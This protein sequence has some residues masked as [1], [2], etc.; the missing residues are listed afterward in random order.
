MSI[1]FLLTC[2][3]FFLMFPVSAQELTQNIRGQIKDKATHL[4]LEG[5]NVV[6]VPSE[7]IM[8]DRSDKEGRFEIRKIPIGRYS[9]QFTYLGYNPIT[10]NDVVLNST[11]EIILNIEMEEKVAVSKD[12]VVKG[13]REKDKPVNELAM[14]SA[15]MFSVEETGRY[16]GSLN[17]PARMAQNFAGVQANG[18]TRNDIIIRGNSPLGV[19]WRLEGIDIPNPN[20]F[21]G[22]GTS[23]GAI[24][25]LN[26]N[27][28]SNSDFLTGAFPAQYGNALAG[29][30]DLRLRNGN[31]QHREYTIM[32][33]M[34]GLEAGIEG[35]IS[36][37]NHSSYIANYRYSTLGLFD[38][39]GI[40]FGAAAIPKY[41]DGVFKLNLPTTHAGEF[42][43][44]GVGGYNSSAFYS[45]DYDTTGRKLNPLPKG[46]N[47]NFI[48]YMGV[49][50]LEHK[51]HFSK[52]TYGK[53]I[54]A[55]SI[56]GNKTNAD[57]LYNQ[58]Q[59]K[60]LWLRRNYGERTLNGQYLLSTK[61][62]AQH[63]TQLGIYYNQTF[64]QIK[65]S[66]YLSSI[67]RYR[68]ILDEDGSIQI[69]RAFVQHQFK[70]NEHVTLVAGLH[71]QLFTLNQSKA[72]EPR[73]GLRF[74]VRKNIWLNGGAGLH[75]QTQPWI[76]YFYRVQ[77]NGQDV[78]TNKDVDFTR[79]LQGVLGVDWLFARNFRLKFETYYQ[80]LSQI[81][82]E[83][84]PSSY[85]LANEGA[86]YIVFNKPDLVNK[87][88][89]YNTGVELTIEKFFSKNYYFLITG[90]VYKSMYQG[91]D[92]V[93]R[94]TAFDGSYALNTLVGYD[95]KLNKKS[96]LS[97]N[98]KATFLGGRRYTPIDEAAS[99]A[100]YTPVYIDSLAF[101]K[102]HPAYFRPDIRISYRL[103]W[104]KVS[105]EW[106]LNINNFIDRDNIQSLEYD[107]TK[108]AV[109]YTYQIGFFPVIQY[110]LEF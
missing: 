80:S 91:S 81:P 60:F 53:F 49:F 83:Q 96:V 85:S 75:H 100:S 25:I 77:Q 99:K 93:E 71:G 2:G 78:A 67:Q 37:K 42:S 110:R 55:Y 98:A 68:K 95:W 103:N 35:P 39:L 63:L 12:V 22:I 9:I 27:N 76:T 43:V 73:I 28:L 84:A 56:N 23:G 64:F 102:Q 108:N 48:N 11:K 24:S 46:F 17:D 70:L 106:G 36:R 79:S 29:V 38:K 90:S 61:W 30:F 52:K 104:R 107:R 1:K 92:G 57:S 82:I 40:N 72:L 58:E 6:V 20:H 45:K 14:V 13:K 31:D 15:R 3:L 50:G 21:S 74:Q 105:Q 26:N 65:D 41:Q 69:I 44:F 59:E 51:Y 33:G 97:I 5:V 88:K 54:V 89:G 4:V 10:V 62:N 32:F 16:A 66:V 87:G 86:Y 19:Q 101:S 7:P 34:N 47:T 94:H 109:G 8:G 18:D